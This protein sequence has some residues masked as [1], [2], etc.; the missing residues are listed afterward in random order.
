MTENKK[1]ADTS[2]AEIEKAIWREDGQKYLFEAKK[3]Q[4]HPALF[5]E[6]FI[7]IV[8]YFMQI[9]NLDNNILSN[10]AWQKS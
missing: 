4:Q 7:P 8:Q 3:V 9:N 1:T 6:A 10:S 2:V 5:R